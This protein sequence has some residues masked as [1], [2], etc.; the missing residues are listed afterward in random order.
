MGGCK[1]SIKNHLV[2]LTKGVIQAVPMG[3]LAQ[4]TTINLIA[5]NNIVANRIR[6]NRSDD[7]LVGVQ[8][9]EVH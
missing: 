4:Q 8:Y 3:T 2:L 9:K 7:N 6:P 5:R 1:N